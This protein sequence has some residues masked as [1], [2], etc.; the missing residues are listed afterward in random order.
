MPM[1]QA[2]DTYWHL[3]SN[4]YG[5]RKLLNAISNLHYF[6]ETK[7]CLGL[8]CPSKTIRTLKEEI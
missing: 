5:R 2:I 7:F 1:A 3:D 6:C 4:G 8:S